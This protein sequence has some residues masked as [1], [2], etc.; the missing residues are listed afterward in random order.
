MSDKIKINAVEYISGDDFFRAVEVGNESNRVLVKPF[1]HNDI[2]I[3]FG[4]KYELTEYIE[5]QGVLIP[6]KNGIKRVFF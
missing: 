5:I 2:K 1:I 3:K 6:E 4:R